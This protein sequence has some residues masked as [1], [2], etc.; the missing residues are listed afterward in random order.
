MS[1]RTVL[2]L[3][4]SER[5]EF[6]DGLVTNRVPSPGE[7][8]RYAA[9]LT[10]QGKY[11]ADFLLIPEEDRLL[12]DVDSALA[13]QLYQKLSMYKLRRDVGV[14]DTGLKV[15]RGTGERPADAWPDPRHPELGWRRYGGTEGDDG[16]DWD[17]L[18]VSL[19][20][21]QSGIELTPDSYILEMGF[22]RLHGVDFKKGCFVGQEVVARM[23]HK[24]ELNKGLRR[25][26]L[27][28]PADPGTP[29]TR[30]GKDVGMLHTVSGEE[31]LAWLRFN[32]AGEGMEADGTPVT[33]LP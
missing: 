30:D 17:A 27:D 28:G 23:K 20:I 29:I 15:E 21:P 8:A 14:E 9:L 25:V 6:L 31:G 5:V 19:G 26:A 1:D 13:P 10:P 33:L 11:I 22:E 2:A 32:R 12:I 18:R 24:T 3:T 7:G 16:T 4:G